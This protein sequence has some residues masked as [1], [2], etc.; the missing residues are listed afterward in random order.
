MLRRR[1][2]KRQEEINALLMKA[3]GTENPFKLW[4]ELG[5]VMTKDCTV[6][7]YNKNLQQTDAKLVE[8][9][10]RY[11]QDQPERPHA[12]GEYDGCVCA[13]ALQHAATGAR[14][15]AGRGACATNRA[16]RTTSRTSPSA[17]TRIG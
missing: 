7:R 17:T 9:L 14:D 10:E 6:I 11:P 1:E 13:A 12:V 3:D 5:E 8:L 4:R 15:C 2:K 16:G